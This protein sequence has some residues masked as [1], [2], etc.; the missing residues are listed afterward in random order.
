MLQTSSH[1]RIQ[2]ILGKVT[3]LELYPECAILYGKVVYTHL[4]HVCVCVCVCVCLTK[5]YSTVLII[6]VTIILVI[7]SLILS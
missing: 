2:L 4:F 5:S 1:Y 3:E 7:L 6:V